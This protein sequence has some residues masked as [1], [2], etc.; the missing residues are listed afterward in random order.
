MRFMFQMLFFVFVVLMLT[1]CMEEESHFDA[2]K[3]LLGEKRQ[4]EA[5]QEFL[6]AIAAGEQTFTI[7]KSASVLGDKT[8][9][10]IKAVVEGSH[11]DINDT[12]SFNNGVITVPAFLCTPLIIDK[13][14]LSEAK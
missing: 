11:P 13:D 6:N 4:P 12:T 3:R 8:V 9:R 7:H 14:N 1:A 5:V 2:A 10:M